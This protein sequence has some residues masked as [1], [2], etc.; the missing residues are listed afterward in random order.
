MTQ[1]SFLPVSKRSGDCPKC[2]GI[3]TMHPA[4]IT[5]LSLAAQPDTSDNTYVPEDYLAYKCGDCGEELVIEKEQE[6]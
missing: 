4:D 6:P 5:T 2:G 3:G 1:L